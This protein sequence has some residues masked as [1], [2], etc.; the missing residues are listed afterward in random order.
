MLSHSPVCSPVG[1]MQVDDE[2]DGILRLDEFMKVRYSH[3]V[4]IDGAHS[5]QNTDKGA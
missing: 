2:S 4:S 3:L 5:E 1:W